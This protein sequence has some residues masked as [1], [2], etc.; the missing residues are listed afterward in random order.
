M[1]YDQRIAKNRNR[2]DGGARGPDPFAEVWPVLLG[3]L[4]KEPDLEA[5]QC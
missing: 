2:A 3:W 5:K 1:K 4:R